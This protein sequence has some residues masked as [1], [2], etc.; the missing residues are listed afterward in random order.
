MPTAAMVPS[1]SAMTDAA[2]AMISVL[3]SEERINS[4]WNSSLYQWNE[5]P[6]QLER[7]F[8]SLKLHTIRTMMGRYRKMKTKRV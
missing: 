2:S 6:V 4:L 7:D 1:S 8:D 5:K 3:R